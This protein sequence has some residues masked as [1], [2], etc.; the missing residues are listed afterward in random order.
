MT[1]DNSIKEK[2]YHIYIRRQI[3]E[4]QQDIINK[5]FFTDEEARE[6]LMKDVVK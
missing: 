1:T 2:E 6:L 3:I 5:K 4:A